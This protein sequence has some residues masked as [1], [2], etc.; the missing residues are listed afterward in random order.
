MPP[1]DAPTRALANV[2]RMHNKLVNF[3]A[4][5]HATCPLGHPVNGG[6]AVFL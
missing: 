4:Q 3:A 5:V 1:A 6:K 2:L